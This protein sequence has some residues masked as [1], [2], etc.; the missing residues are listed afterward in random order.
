MLF[1]AVRAVVVAR[2]NLIG[3]KVVSESRLTTLLRVPVRPYGVSHLGSAHNRAALRPAIARGS[4]PALQWEGGAGL[5]HPLTGG[6]RGYAQL[7]GPD[8]QGREA[9]RAH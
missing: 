8:P 2:L 1:P 6:G 5:P 3:I 7:G 4:R 9:E